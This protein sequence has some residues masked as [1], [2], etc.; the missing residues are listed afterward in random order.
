M[1]IM[2]AL[3]DLFENFGK[4]IQQIEKEALIAGIMLCSHSAITY[5]L[6]EC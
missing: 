3:C 6:W 5:I 2:N 1:V 4:I